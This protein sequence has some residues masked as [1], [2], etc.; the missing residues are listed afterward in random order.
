VLA[1]A[2]GV[3]VSVT[4]GIPDNNPVGTIPPFDPM[5]ADG[6]NIVEDIGAGRYVFYAHLQLGSIPARVRAGA[7]L[8]A[9]DM[10]GRLGNSG[11]SLAPHLHF[12]VSD[13]PS[14]LDSSGLPFA[15][16]VQM[17]EG[18]AP[19]GSL[20]NLIQGAPVPIDRTGAGVRRGL[21]PARNGVFGYN[22]SR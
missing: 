17:F 15:F 8:S 1:A 12:Q 9:G 10:I 16:D 20:S 5:H 11:S 13:T 22:L 3:V 14:L 18:S 4:R 6:N 21:M 7:R 19:E 2:P